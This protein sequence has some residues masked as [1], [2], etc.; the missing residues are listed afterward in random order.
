MPAFQSKYPTTTMNKKLCGGL[1]LLSVCV[2]LAFTTS[3]VSTDFVTAR[4]DVF[5]DSL[6]L[7]VA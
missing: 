7:L 4:L 6:H 3:F 2:S 1:L 5:P